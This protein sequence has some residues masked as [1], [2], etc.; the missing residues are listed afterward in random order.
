MGAVPADFAPVPD[1]RYVGLEPVASRSLARALGA[2]GFGAGVSLALSAFDARHALVGGALASLTAGAALRQRGSRRIAKDAVRMAIVP[3]GVLVD[4]YDAPRILRWAAVRKV[5]VETTRA[6]HILGGD[7]GFSSRVVITTDHESFVGEASGLVPL[8]R[9]VVHLD[10]YATEQATPLALD[11][12]GSADHVAVLE[13]SEPGAEPLLDG[14]REWLGTATAVAR[15]GL[16]PGGYRRVGALAPT[17][18]AVEV[19]R[20]TLQ[21]RTPRP[22]DPRAFAAI[23]AAELRATELVPELVSLTQ[24]PQP[25]VAAAAKQ[26]ARRLGVAEARTGTLDEVAPFLFDVDRMRLETWVALA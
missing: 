26:A 1:F 13:P 10:A 15:L 6:P 14:V 23:V 24:C 5:D 4:A 9:L 20:R 12:D 2:V 19:L 7:H 11:L 25:L 21:S 17:P 8:E 22:R 16:A 3:W 18:L